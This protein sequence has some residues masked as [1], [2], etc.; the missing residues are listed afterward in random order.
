MYRVWYLSVQ[1]GLK[2]ES[3]PIS[4]DFMLFE[5]GICP[6]IWEF[7]TKQQNE[8]KFCAFSIYLAYF[9]KSHLAKSKFVCITATKLQYIE[10][11]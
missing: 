10:R 5:I 9:N 4:I 3:S 6:W 2:V 1:N 8:W 11:H 7:Y